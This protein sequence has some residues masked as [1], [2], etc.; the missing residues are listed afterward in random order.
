MS[1]PKGPETWRPNRGGRLGPQEPHGDPVSRG[2]GGVAWLPPGPPPACRGPGTSAGVASRAT[3]AAP[4]QTR[5]AH[6]RHPPGA[7][8]RGRQPHSP[9]AHRGRPTRRRRR[10]RRGSPGACAPAS[11]CGSPR[12]DGASA[13]PRGWGEVS[14]GRRGAGSGAG[15]GAEPRGLRGAW[16]R[17]WAK[18]G[19]GGRRRGAW[20][21]GGLGAAPLP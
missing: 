6:S 18:T 5:V 20:F 1:A 10:H 12:P 7:G 9:P 19:R 21:W 14:Q 16:S 3:T 11:V 15:S 2:R 8:H 13:P 4:A 17:P